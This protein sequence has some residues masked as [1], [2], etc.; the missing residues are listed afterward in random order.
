MTYAF[1]GWAFVSK[2]TMRHMQA[3][4]NWVL[5]VIEQSHFDNEMLM[6]KSFIKSLNLTLY[7]PASKNR[8][9]KPRSDSL[10][11]KRGV[12]KP[13]YISLSSSKACNGA[14]ETSQ[15]QILKLINGQNYSKPKSQQRPSN[16]N[17]RDLTSLC[18]HSLRL[19][20]RNLRL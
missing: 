10:V 14:P 18:E 16:N 9:I 17:R 5:G 15:T 2:T 1:P 3:V 13:S 4:Q 11:D 7:V 20:D 8:Y 12:K 19:R 6:L